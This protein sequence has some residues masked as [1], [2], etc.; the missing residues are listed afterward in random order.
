MEH[1]VAT[2]IDTHIS[3]HNLG[4]PHR[5]AYKKSHSTELLLVKMMED[6]RRAV[7]KNLVVGIAYVDFR[8]AFD[9]ISHYVLLEKLQAVGV[10]DDLL[11][12]IKDYLADRSQ[13]TVVN[14]FQ[15]ETLPVK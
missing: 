10:A 15:S 4:H 1:A 9:S 3:E 5:W 6:W 14:G 7:D 2:T 13:V 11:C 12:W 8:K